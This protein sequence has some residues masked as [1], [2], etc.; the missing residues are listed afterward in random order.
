MLFF[1]CLVLSEARIHFK[2][3][4]DAGNTICGK[5]KRTCLKRGERTDSRK[6]LTD[7]VACKNRCAMIKY[8]SLWSSSVCFVERSLFL[9]RIV[10]FPRG[11]IGSLCAGTDE[12]ADVEQQGEQHEHNGKKNHKQAYSLRYPLFSYPV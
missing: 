9:L 6:A 11:A 10:L 5:E 12:D 8:L 7:K 3:Q 2:K 4:I 1:L